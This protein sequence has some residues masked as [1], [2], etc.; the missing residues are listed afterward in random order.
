MSRRQ[1]LMMDLLK[2]YTIT[3]NPAS[4]S[5]NVSKPLNQLLIPFT[6]VQELY[7]MSSPYPAGASKNLIPDGTN[8]D[9][10]YVS[11]YALHSDG[12]MTSSV[13][14]YVSEY[15]PV[16]GESNY[17][18][19][20]TTTYSNESA[21]CFYDSNKEYISGVSLSQ[22]LSQ[23]VIAPSNAVY[24]RC[25]QVN[26]EY[27]YRLGKH[28]IQ[29]EEGTTATTP[30]WYSNVCP[31]FGR[32]Q[33]S[34]TRRGI[35]FF[36]GEMENGDINETTGKN[37]GASSSRRRTKNYIPFDPA[38]G[39][40]YLVTWRSA[41]RIFF[42][43]ENKL[44]IGYKSIGGGV[45]NVS[46]LIG[47]DLAQEVRYIRVRFSS[48]YDARDDETGMNYPATE[49]EFIPYSGA[50]IPVTFP[51]VGKNL[52]NENDPAIQYGKFVNSTGDV[53]NATYGCISATIKVKPDTYYAFSRSD[54]AG[55]AAYCS[56]YDSEGN[57]L[58]RANI[59][60][61]S[62]VSAIVKT[63]ASADHCVIVF[64]SG[65]GTTMSSSVLQ[66]YQ[67]Q[68]EEGS[69]ATEYEEFDNTV[70][71]GTLDLTTGVLTVEWRARDMSLLNWTILSSGSTTFM[72]SEIWDKAKTYNY[73]CEQYKTVAKNRTSLGNNEL[74]LYHTSESYRNRLAIRDDRYT[75]VADLKAG[76]QGILVAYELVESSKK[77]I[78]LTPQQI[79]SL[80]GDNV[81]FTDTN[82]QN[83]VKYL[84]KG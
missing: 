41:F 61:G 26:K 54:A 10:G 4:F 12:T 42:Y 64:S 36:D 24:A 6:P 39:S 76:L 81:I 44:F 80:I 52:F 8:T 34:T 17:V 43:N 29:F 16:V 77:T 46:S 60:I 75:T 83:T 66:S 23:Q 73:I 40:F 45:I 20:Q 33:I 19:S 30:K 58:A 50:T 65:S 53:I 78:Q 1:M 84:K 48:G 68:M 72:T 69:S 27:Y 11:G 32:T 35:N 47:A 28:L 49:T 57:F 71:G 18:L 21:V 82:G 5:T 13:Y 55:P 67:I 56:Q 37:S 74:G 79:Q 14:C 31:I 15:F 7:G 63:N 70:Y 2:E 62:N 3:G 25:T 9:N 38:L 22:L 59:A 51:A